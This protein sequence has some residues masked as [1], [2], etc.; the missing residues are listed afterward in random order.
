MPEI[1]N[2]EFLGSNLKDLEELHLLECGDLIDYFDQPLIDNVS[3]KEKIIK[4]N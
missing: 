4:V 3:N 2:I 1:K